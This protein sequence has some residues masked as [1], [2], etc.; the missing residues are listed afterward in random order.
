M[1]L[2]QAPSSRARQACFRAAG[3]AGG[4][5]A[6]AFLLILT[7]ACQTAHVPTAASESFPVDREIAAI[8]P[9]P[10]ARPRGASRPPE[11]ALPGNTSGIVLLRPAAPAVAAGTSG[12]ESAGDPDDLR[13]GTEGEAEALLIREPWANPVARGGLEAA[14]V[15]LRFDP[16]H[17]DY[18]SHALDFPARRRLI[19]YCDWLEANPDVHVTLEGHCDERGSSDYN[20]N[21]GM[22]R[23]WAVK[24]LMVARGIEAGRIFTISYGEEQ[25]IAQG[26][27]ARAYALNRRVEFR[28]FYPTRDGQFLSSLKEG[29]PG[30]APETPSGV[31]PAQ[32]PLKL[33]ESDAPWPPLTE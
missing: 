6:A 32:P 33:G 17:F 11:D 29:L 19:A 4:R 12:G 16:V 24:D 15:G 22:T 2:R 5:L 9:V 18:D 25:P 28:P 31:P 26:R 10:E 8:P 3:G 14:D 20:Y 21:L 1:I 23:A 13:E 7:T 30:E 27:S